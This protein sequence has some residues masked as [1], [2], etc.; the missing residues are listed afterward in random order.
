[1]IQPLKL[2]F[3][4]T[5]GTNEYSI[6]AP[7]VGQFYDIEVSKQILGK[8]F[9]NSIVK[10]NTFGAQNA[11]DMIDIEAHLTV[12]VPDFVKDIKVK[13][14]KDLGIQD[15]NQIREVYIDNFIPWWKNIHESLKINEDEVDSV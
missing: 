1:M 8:G 6:N 15:Y 11:A 14:F 12:L 10:T 13:T 2:S 4:T 7:T 9:Y 5:Q 3:T